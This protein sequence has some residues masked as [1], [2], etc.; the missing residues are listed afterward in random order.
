MLLIVNNC[1]V[2]ITDGI[3]VISIS[4]DISICYHMFNYK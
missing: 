4:A 2:N 1:V 3:V